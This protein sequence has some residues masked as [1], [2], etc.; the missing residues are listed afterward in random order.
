MTIYDDFTKPQYKDRDE[1]PYPVRVYEY[2][3]KGMYGP[4]IRCESEEELKAWFL[5]H[6]PKL[7]R[8]KRELRIT[9]TGDL[10]VFHAKNGMI[11]Y[12]GVRHTPEG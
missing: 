8:E 6:F 5:E 7:M 12:D 4:P 3:A 1:S 2:N 11:V 10:M 9:D